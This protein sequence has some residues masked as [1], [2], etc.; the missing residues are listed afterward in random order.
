MMISCDGYF[1]KVNSTKTGKNEGNINLENVLLEFA[2]P[3]N[4]NNIAQDIFI[5]YGNKL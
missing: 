2:S 4:N 3:I 5:E 1:C